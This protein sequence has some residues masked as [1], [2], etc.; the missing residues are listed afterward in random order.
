MATVSTFA[1]FVSAGLL[2]LV[3]PMVAKML[4]PAL[5]G[6]PAV[7]STCMLFFQADLLVGYLYAHALTR[8]LKP[9]TQVLLHSV[10]ILVPLAFLPIRIAAGS[11]AAGRTP[12]AWLLS[13]L[14]VAV[15]VPFA[16]LAASGPLFQRWFAQ[17]GREGSAEPY[18]L[19]AASNLGSLVALLGY[20]FVL[21]PSPG[22]PLRARRSSRR[23]SPSPRRASSGRSGTSSSSGSPWR[24]APSCS[25]QGGKRHP[26]PRRP[27]EDRR[28]RFLGG[29]GD[30]G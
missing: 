14:A 27:R 20:P 6:A 24:A 13:A 5:G 7:W 1:V 26:L 30:C 4:L 17:S 21:E 8:Y 19:Y 15:G 12:V 22:S 29:R 18:S 23:D 11:P 10:V 2:F 9:R 16:V 25:G 28:R 3:Q